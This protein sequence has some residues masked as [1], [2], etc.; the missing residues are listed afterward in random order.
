M[1]LNMMMMLTGR[2]RAEAEY[3]DLLTGSGFRLEHVIPTHTPFSVIQAAR[4]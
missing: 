3:R 1:D 2:E 4:Q